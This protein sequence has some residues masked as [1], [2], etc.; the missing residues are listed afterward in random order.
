[1][2]P[3]SAD[4]PGLHVLRS[5]GLQGDAIEALH[6][7]FFPLKDSHLNV[8]LHLTGLLHTFLRGLLDSRLT[9]VSHSHIT[10]TPT[11]YTPLSDRVTP[12]PKTFHWLPI[13]VGGESWLLCTINRLFLSWRHHAS[14]APAPMCPVIIICAHIFVS[15]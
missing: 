11:V 13:T 9:S 14:S 8:P 10:V 12:L 7:S 15:H 6:A 5:V 3:T 1:M 2:L 4:P